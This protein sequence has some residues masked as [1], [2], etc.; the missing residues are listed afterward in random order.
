M[1]HIKYSASDTEKLLGQK[2]Y[3]HIAMHQNPNPFITCVI[4]SKII[5]SLM[6]RFFDYKKG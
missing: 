6:I 4:L 3:N 5:N 1:K 2:K